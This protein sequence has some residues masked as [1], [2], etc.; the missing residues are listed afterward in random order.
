MLAKLLAVNTDNYEI[1]KKLMPPYYLDPASL[2]SE[3][4]YND[5]LTRVANDLA[6][7]F[8]I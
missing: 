6:K 4:E 8:G 5:N 1:W 3:K 2:N 7:A